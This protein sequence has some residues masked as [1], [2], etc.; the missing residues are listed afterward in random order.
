MLPPLHIS[1]PQTHLSN[2]YCLSLLAVVKNTTTKSNLWG[3]GFTSPWIVEHQQTL[4]Q[5]LKSGTWRQELKHRQERV[6]LTPW[7]IPHDFFSLHSHKIQENLPR[8]GITYSGLPPS[9]INKKKK[10]MP[11]RYLMEKIP[12]PDDCTL[13]QVDR[14]WP[15]NTIFLRKQ[16]L[17]HLPQ[18][19]TILNW[20]IYLKTPKSLKLSAIKIV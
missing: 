16:F 3:K 20:I 14:K 12:L 1:D 10:K 18:Y 5:T 4:R 8:G 15:A 11:H 13:C 19:W 9:T 6:L 7:Y 17:Q 2:M